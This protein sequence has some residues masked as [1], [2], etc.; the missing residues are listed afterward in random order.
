MVI[1]RSKSN[2]KQFYVCDLV[3]Q[4]GFMYHSFPHN[5]SEVKYLSV[6]LFCFLKNDDGET[7]RVV[8]T[9]SLHSVPEYQYAGH[10]FSVQPRLKVLDNEVKEVIFHS[11]ESAG[12]WRLNLLTF[13]KYFK[14]LCP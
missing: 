12:N 10:E 5:S 7:I 11:D 13:A 1:S 6:I 8:T 9:L 3:L 4:K 2:C 14:L